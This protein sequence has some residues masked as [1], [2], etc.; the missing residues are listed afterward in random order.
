MDPLTWFAALLV[1]VALEVVA[2]LL[3]PKPKK[4]SAAA[5]DVS[6]PTADASRPLPV[7]FG[8][9]TISGTNILW[10]G[11]VSTRQRTINA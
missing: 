8:S 10:Y 4:S 11:E 7:V 6:F 1:A 2:Y 5:Q 3:M 9:M